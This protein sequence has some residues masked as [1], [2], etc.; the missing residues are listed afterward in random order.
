M[1]K[2]RKILIDADVV[3]HFIVAGEINVINQIFPAFQIWIL[4]KVHAELQQ[5]PS[6]SVRNQISAILSKKV[7]RL[8]PFPEENA[9][10]VKEYLWIKTVLFK[11]DGESASLAVA[12]HNKDIL[13]SSNLRDIANYCK[14][15]RIDFLTTMDF[16]CEALR[17][18]LFSIKRCDEFISK[19]LAAGSR[20]PVRKMSEYS[21]TKKL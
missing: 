19:V 7:L 11:G 8:M 1:V 4:D 20:L 9:T 21:C 17:T 10:I 14:M 2:N 13:A 3:S 16:L 15:H 12:R 5:W 18:G 6:V